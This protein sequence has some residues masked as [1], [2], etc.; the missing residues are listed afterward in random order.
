VRLST[1]A[2]IISRRMR[3][4]GIEALQAFQTEADSNTISRT[5]VNRFLRRVTFRGNRT[6]DMTFDGAPRAVRKLL[7]RRRVTLLLPLLVS[8]LALAPG[9]A[10]P[11]HASTIA[12]NSLSDGA[13]PGKCTLRE[14]IAAANT[15]A[16]VGACAAGSVFPEVDTITINF[17]RFICKQSGCT[18]ILASPLPA[19]TEDVTIA[20]GSP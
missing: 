19:I 2:Q 13:D 14:A 3:R 15:N 11:A 16:A 18:I 10:T 8:A 20:G 9:G 7:M 17:S 6:S 5:T 4:L 1:D 12:V